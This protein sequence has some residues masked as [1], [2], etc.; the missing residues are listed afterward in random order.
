MAIESSIPDAD[1]LSTLVRELFDHLVSVEIG[2]RA[3]VESW[4]FR[5]VGVLTA[6]AAVVDGLRERLAE[7]TR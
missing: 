7:A 3:Q 6:Q 2:N 4:L 1:T 5:L